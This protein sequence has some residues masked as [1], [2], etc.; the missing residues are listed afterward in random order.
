MEKDHR[1]SDIE[2]ISELIR[3]SNE[4]IKKFAL[5]RRSSLSTATLDKYLE[6]TIFSGL[7]AYDS[8]KGVYQATDKGKNAL[9]IF[10]KVTELTGKNRSSP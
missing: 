2:I 8:E 10:Y 6:K 1:R 4:P 7:I 5:G 9:S 3:N